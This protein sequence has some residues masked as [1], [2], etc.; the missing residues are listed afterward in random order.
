MIFVLTKK[1]RDIIHAHNAELC[2]RIVKNPIDFSRCVIPPG[3]NGNR[4]LLF[5]GRLSVEKRVETIIWAI[6]RT[7][8]RWNLKI[9]GD[10]DERERLERI[11]SE[12]GLE[13]QVYFMGWKINPW[14]YADDVSAL[15]LASE[16]EGFPVAAIEAMACGI[17]VI[18][19][20]VDGIVEIIR[21]GINGFLFP[22]GD[23]AALSD[24]LDAI[25]SGQMP[26]TCPQIIRE[27]IEDYEEG[28][29]LAEF[30]DEIFGI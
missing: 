11:V 17:P 14:E 22:Q 30:R 24:I 27:M 3:A 2:V 5:V 15:V 4:T 6:G 23:C 16:Y 29:A 9:I 13:E 12:L 7:K 25:S 20:P 28:K 18:S 10:G 26:A 8:A 19:T 21:P 1:S